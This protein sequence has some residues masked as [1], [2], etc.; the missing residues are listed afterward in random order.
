MDASRD[1]AQP[2]P[3][4]GHDDGH[5]APIRHLLLQVGAQ[6]RCARTSPFLLSVRKKRCG[7]CDRR[8]ERIG[9]SGS[10]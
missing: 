10:S 6:R 8:N 9:C 3:G 5:G 2:R 1:E 4:G 7:R